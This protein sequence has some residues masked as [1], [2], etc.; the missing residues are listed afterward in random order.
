VNK[1]YSQDY[2]VVV[3]KVLTFFPASKLF[4]TKTPRQRRFPLFYLKLSFDH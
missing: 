1:V 4:R 2:R 3:Y